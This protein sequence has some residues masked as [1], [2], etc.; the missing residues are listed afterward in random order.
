MFLQSKQPC[1]S[2]QSP[3]LDL[4]FVGTSAVSIVTYSEQS[5]DDLQ[6]GTMFPSEHWLLGDF[7]EFWQL[8]AVWVQ[9][10]NEERNQDQKCGAEFKAI[11]HNKSICFSILSMKKKTNQI[12]KPD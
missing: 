5:Q 1:Q 3:E 7:A 8:A 11:T 9:D 12:G 4:D 10:G 6:I 2:T